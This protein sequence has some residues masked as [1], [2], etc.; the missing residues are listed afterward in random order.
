MA[1]AGT[2]GR[3]SCDRVAPMTDYKTTPPEP[4]FAAPARTGPRPMLLWISPSWRSSWTS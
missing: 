1:R 4:I 3:S 2:T